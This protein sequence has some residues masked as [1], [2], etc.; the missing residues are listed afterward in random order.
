MS[1]ATQHRLKNDGL[2]SRRNFIASGVSAL[3]VS[4]LVN[5]SS[6]SKIHY[7][8]FK[9]IAFDAFPIFDPRPVFAKANQLFGEKGIE[10]A[11]QWRITQFEHTWL[12]AVAG[13]YKD[14][15]QVT[16]E[17]L[18]FA[19]AKTGNVLSNTHKDELMQQYLSLTTWPDVVP[20]LQQLKQQGIHLS[21]LSNMTNEMLNS[22]MKH[23]GIEGYFD[24][25]I[26]TD[27]AHSYK[28]DPKA[29]ELGTN[30]LKL[31]KQEILFVAFA[32]WDACGA[33]WF[34]YPTFWMNRLKA[35]EEQLGVKPDGTGQ[36][37]AE[38]INFIR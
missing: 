18:L 28:P 10:L 11:N 1:F 30:I 35:P 7:N 19:A 26:S 33:K 8:K 12:R 29:Y 24:H 31:K 38:L 27:R 13:R 6:N 15:W 37:M 5:S 17:A 4:G 36:G 23:S 9:A 14:F 34:G 20:S 22:G 21:F 25:A 2:I 3:A 16:E 32:G